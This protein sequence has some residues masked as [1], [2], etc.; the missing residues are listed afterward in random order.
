MERII[1]RKK[2]EE[3]RNSLRMQMTSISNCMGSYNIPDFEFCIK[4]ANSICKISKDHR[5]LNLIKSKQFVDMLF[6]FNEFCPCVKF[7][8]EQPKDYYHYF[9]QAEF[10]NEKLSLS[11]EILSDSVQI[12]NNK[13][14]YVSNL[15]DYF[16][17][18]LVRNNIEYSI[19]EK[20]L[21]IQYGIK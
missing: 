15:R 10:G 14:D 3:I 6:L 20:S 9:I 21:K 8:L 4:E 16:K 19:L 18:P 11:Y 1:G 5:L 2:I 12:Y 13:G 17:E 7:S